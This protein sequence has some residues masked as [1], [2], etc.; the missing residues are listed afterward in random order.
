MKQSDS[1][2][3]PEGLSTAGTGSGRKSREA[4][5]WIR[6]LEPALR[7]TINGMTVAA[8]LNG[9]G[10]SSVSRNSVNVDE[11]WVV[12]SGGP[13]E[14]DIGGPVMNLVPR[15][16]GNN[17]RGQ[18]FIINAGDSSRGN[19]LDDAL[20]APPPGPN[21]KETPGMIRSYDFNGSHGGPIKA[22]QDV[23]LR[24]QGDRLAP[25]VG[26]PRTRAP[27]FVLSAAAGP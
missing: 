7:M 3:Q 11:V 1:R 6:K 15:A 19:N 5:F 2:Y 22:R 25:E 23:V 4:D 12:V 9:S 17:L 27:R 24:R 10:V 26:P 18:A 16:G 14:S 21:L 8:A 20:T 13:G